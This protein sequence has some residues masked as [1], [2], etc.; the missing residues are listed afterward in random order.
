MVVVSHLFPDSPLFLLLCVV[1]SCKF[2]KFTQIYHKNNQSFEHII[3]KSGGTLKKNPHHLKYKL[4]LW[5]V[6]KKHIEY[7]FT[8]Y[9]YV[10]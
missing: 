8:N 6:K 2:G 10:M 9:T 5:N 4:N 3:I 1:Y 7:D